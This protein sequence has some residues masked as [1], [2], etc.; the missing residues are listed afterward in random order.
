MALATI[1]LVAAVILFI[2][3]ALGVGS[4][5]NLQSAG[6]ACLAAAFLAGR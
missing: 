5:I 1:F 2:L 4:R 6:L 3:S